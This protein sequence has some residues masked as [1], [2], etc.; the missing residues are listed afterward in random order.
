MATIFWLVAKQ[1][2]KR[3]SENLFF[4]VKKWFLCFFCYSIR[5]IMK[6][7]GRK[8]WKIEGKEKWKVVQPTK[9]WKRGWKNPKDEKWWSIN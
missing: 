3:K 6:M 1:I 7:I 2:F 8:V 5:E 9:G 4:D